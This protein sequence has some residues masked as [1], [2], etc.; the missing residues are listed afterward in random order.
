[1]SSCVLFDIPNALSVQ[2]LVEW[3]RLKHV[4]RLDSAICTRQ[5]RSVPVS[6]VWPMYEV[7]P[8]V[9]LSIRKNG[10]YSNVDHP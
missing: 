7:Y 8:A 2:I 6:S 9:L 3:L 5:L 1:M 10:A 4:V